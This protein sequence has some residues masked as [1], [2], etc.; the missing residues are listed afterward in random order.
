MRKNDKMNL[1]S[2]KQIF[3]FTKKIK[4]KKDEIS[5]NWVSND[6]Q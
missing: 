3:V 5:E 2:R 4:G 1:K 6:N